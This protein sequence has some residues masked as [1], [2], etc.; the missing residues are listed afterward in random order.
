MAKAWLCGR[1]GCRRLPAWAARLARSARA[2]RML[3]QCGRWA[4]G[5]SGS[6]G[7]LDVMVVG[8]GAALRSVQRRKVGIGREM[9]CVAPPA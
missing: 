7:G 5:D 3:L 6:T 2:N 1:H 8:R 4:G 9:R